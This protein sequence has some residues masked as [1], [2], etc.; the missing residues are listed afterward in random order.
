MC[1]SMDAVAD[2]YRC[3][4]PAGDMLFTDTQCHEGVSDTVD[5][6]EPVIIKKARPV[7]L[8]EAEL[9]ALQKLDKK[10]ADS[11]R[12]RIKRRQQIDR[13]IRKRNGIKRQNCLLANAQMAKIQ[14]KKSHGYTLSEADELDQ[15]LRELELTKRVNC[16]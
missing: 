12:Q 9:K 14:Y 13:Q 10:I 6:P 3:K 2:I 8:N 7:V 5:L 16:D 1:S 15:Q 4:L 11:R